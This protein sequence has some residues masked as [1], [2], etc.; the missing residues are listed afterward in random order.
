MGKLIGI[1]FGLKRTGLALTDELQIIAS[2]YKTVDSTELMKE[3]HRLVQKGGIDTLVLGL[4]KTLDNKPTDLTPNVLELEKALRQQFPQLKVE[5][6]DERFTSSMAQQALISGG[7]SK[8]NRQQ[9]EQLDKISA[10]LIL[11]SYMSANFRP[12]GRRD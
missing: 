7:M 11:Q 6:Y 8:K 3:L 12:P 4:P 2:P 1:D 9:K 5:L 10:T